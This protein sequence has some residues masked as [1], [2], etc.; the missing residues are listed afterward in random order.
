MGKVRK[1][2]LKK[3]THIKKDS[4]RA[5][6]RKK[7]WSILIAVVM[8]GSVAGFISFSGNSPSLEYNGFDILQKCDLY[9][10][11]GDTK[12][13]YLHPQQIAYVTVDPEVI[14]LLKGAV[15]VIPSY[16]LEGNNTQAMA[17]AQF[18]LI[19]FFTAEGKSSGSAALNENNFGIPILNCD[20]STI[21]TPIIEIRKGNSSTVSL[22]GDCIVLEGRT[23]RDFVA[24]AEKVKYSLLGIIE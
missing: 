2:K 19:N 10:L 4:S 17:L 6:T 15:Q 21:Y 22:E 14:N 1:H 9:Y 13:F 12:P 11:K 20:N 7:V 24:A 8:I 5:D 23:D 18:S 3:E 16:D